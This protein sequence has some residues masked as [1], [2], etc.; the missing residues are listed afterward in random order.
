MKVV[1]RYVRSSR[2]SCRSFC[3]N[4]QERFYFVRSIPNIK[5]L[6]ERVWREVRPNFFL[7]NSLSRHCVLVTFY[8]VVAFP[9]ARLSGHATTLVEGEAVAP[10][11]A[12]ALRLW[13]PPDDSY[14]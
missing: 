13:L 6:S 5:R 10:N 7:E 14:T 1:G 12:E 8:V 11:K 9:S 4:R 2:L 3:F